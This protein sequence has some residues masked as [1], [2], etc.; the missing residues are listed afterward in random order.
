[1]LELL[2]R[3]DGQV[4]VRGFRIELA[5]V[6]AVLARHPGVSGAVVVVLEDTLGEKRLAA[7]VVPG[8][9]PGPTTS[10]LRRWLKGRMPEPMVPSSYVFLEAL[11]LS[12]NGKLDRSAL[13]PPAPLEDDGSGTEYVPPRTTV[14]E[15]LAG[16]TADLMH[17]S[18][19]G[20]HDN[21]FEIG[22]DSILGIQM[23]SR[24]RQAGLAL[25]PTD[26]FRHPNIAELAAAAESN[27]VP[28][29]SS[30][31]STLTVAPF[32]LT[33]EGIDL[34]AVKRAYADNG[35]IEDLYPLTPVQEGMLFHTLADPEAGHYVEQ[36][37]CRLRGELDL[38][39]L[40]ES[41]HRL[42]ARHPA[43][44][45]TIH[46]TEF[47]RPYQVVHRG[48]DHP[49][50]Y[51]DWRELTPSE[52]DERLTAYL[53][54]DR[55]RGF[56][57]SR[58]PLSRLAL[59]RL[60]EDVH[61]LI[62]SIHHVVIDGWCLSVLLHETLDI[63]EAI[64]RTREP[65]LKPSRPFR[66]YVA[67]LRDQDDERAEGHWR[68]VLSGVTA[69]TPLGLDG[70]SSSRRGAAP[71]AVAERETLLPA[72]LT[73][74]LLALGRSRRLTLSTLI[75][76]AWALL[77]SRYSGRSDVVF[78]VTV[79][80]RPPELS[81][82]ESMV[83]MFINALPLRVPVIEESY[84]V[85]WLRELQ[86]TMVELRRFEAIPLSRIQA[87]SEVPPGMPLFE[88]LLIV[89]N[90]PFVASLQERANRLGIESARY[91]ERTHY[92]LA[93]TVLPGTELGIKIG[94]DAHRFDPCTIERTL[95]HLRTVLEGMAVDPDR[96]LVD[97]P[98]MMESEQEQLIGQWN[99]SQ[100]EFPLDEQDLDQLT[101][102]E[103]DT[104]IKR[105]GG[106]LRKER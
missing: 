35:G 24:A 48:V 92:P 85:P 83:G 47:D 9:L 73:G 72:D 30:G 77:L 21:F 41:W 93:V 11:P 39:A 5:E 26:L 86:A 69:A 65:A 37:L 60:G 101:E 95:G 89:Q 87:W 23:V 75:Q 80:G 19:V 98:S 97:L 16:I 56:D 71:E 94:F 106:G 74:A 15:I 88:S 50:D 96:R 52:Q 29:G 105:L 18:R 27:S 32:E 20:V 31:T 14:E 8:T 55:R 99:R 7:Y 40:Q 22:V 10:D 79:S 68:H 59:L 45:S 78:G 42:V 49:L 53:G 63:D 57:P 61:Q 46:W 1:V 33:P 36:F 44:R 91:L 103:L 17:R 84:L 100:G 13:P 6:E 76:G 67:W 3:R 70:L 2:G 82:V 102:E 66:D 34:E 90:L 4:K 43:L 12:A 81:G 62:W 104:L 38:P 51:Q 58:P 64:R 25:D 28:L 54:S